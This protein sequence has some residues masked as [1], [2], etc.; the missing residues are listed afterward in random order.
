MSTKTTRT[1]TSRGSLRDK[2]KSKVDRSSIKT[3]TLLYFVIYAIILI[4]LIWCLQ[5]FFVDNYYQRMKIRETNQ[6]SR[7]LESLYEKSTEKF[8]A[9]ALH[10]SL[11]NG[12]TIRVETPDSTTVYEN[13]TEQDG[14]LAP[15]S[16]EIQAAREQL[17]Q[18]SF[19]SASVI[20]KDNNNSG[21]SRLVHVSY[22]G[23]KDDGNMLFVVAPLYPVRS[24][25]SILRQQLVYISFIAMVIATVLAYLMSIRLASPIERI[26]DSAIELS[27]GDYN[28]KFNGGMFTETKE[29]ARTLNTASYEMQKTDSYQK[30]LIANV[31]HDLKTPLT[32]IKSYAEMIDDISGDDPVKRKQH[33]HVIIQEAD[34]LNKLVT[35]MLSVSRLQSNTLELNKEKFNIAEAASEVA[36]TYKV[37][38]EQGYTVD[39]SI[40]K[41]TWVF[42]DQERLKQV[43]SNYISN[44]I[45]YGGEKK[46]I[47]IELKRVG[48]KVRFDVV[49]HGVGI[50]ADEISHV[51]DRYYRTSANHDR[52]IEGS[53]LGLSIVKGILTLHNA[54]YGVDSKEGSGSDFWF[55]MDTVRK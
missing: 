3:V 50:P 41:A 6:T 25:I 49:D 34:R 21:Y 26:T 31:S 52:N 23:D 1:K 7:T 10:Y 19:S 36:D 39:V 2:F 43:M 45:K 13:G 37:M 55:E 27:H 20:V 29:L 28:V 16:P 9:T 14:A 22:L 40:C 30:D 38:S 12:V 11:S 48:R 8:A 54:D 24:T 18:S 47:K 33:L 42:G 53:G 32:M 51:W 5:T 4:L 35:D 46:Y 17:G 15:F 44:A